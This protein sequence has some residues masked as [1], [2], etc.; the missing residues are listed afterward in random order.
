GCLRTKH[1]DEISNECAHLHRHEPAARIDGVD[2]DIRGTAVGRHHALEYAAL[3]LCTDVPGG[4]EADSQAADDGFADDFAGV[5]LENGVR[6]EDDRTFGAFQTPGDLRS[7][8]NEPVAL[9][10]HE[11]ARLTMLLEI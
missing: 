9:Q 7:G 11:I 8:R 3:E 4:T 5:S 6:L 10:V 1:T 2:V